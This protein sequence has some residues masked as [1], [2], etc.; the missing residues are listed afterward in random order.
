VAFQFVGA[1]T[2]RKTNIQPKPRDEILNLLLTTPQESNQLRTALPFFS[3]KP[4]SARSARESL[5]FQRCPPVPHASVLQGGARKRSLFQLP[6]P[7]ALDTD[8]FL[9]HSKKITIAF[10][11]PLPTGR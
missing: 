10:A 7:S 6:A 4:K 11:S 1:P 5:P 8:D 2:D 3:R 9:A